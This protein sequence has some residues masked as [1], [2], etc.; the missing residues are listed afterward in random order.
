M[1][2]ARGARSNLDRHSPESDSLLPPAQA[3]AMRFVPDAGRRSGRAMWLR[4][5]ERQ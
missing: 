5:H 3:F 2:A 1:V 4:T